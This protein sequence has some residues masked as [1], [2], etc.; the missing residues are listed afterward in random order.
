M[1]QPHPFDHLAAD[2]DR[3][4]SASPIARLLR[5]RVHARLADHFPAGAHL[6]ELGCGTGEDACRLAERGV[7][8]TATDASLLMLA[9]TR[10]KTA[11]LP[12]V[13]V[14]PLD[15]DELPPDGLVGPFDGVFSNFGP[16]NCLDT[17]APLAVWLAARVPPG[18]TAAFG[19]MSRWCVWET[20][21]HGLHGDFQTAARRWGGR[22][23]FTPAPGAAPITIRYPSPGQLAREFAP[24]FQRIGLEPLGLLLPPTAIYPVIE[25]RPRLLRTLAR[26][27][28]LTRRLSGLASL[29]DHYWITLRRTDAPAPIP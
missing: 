19:I 5:D 24:W 29:A 12:L 14:Q 6:L 15:L 7:R 3:D 2:Y 23:Q 22:S 18:G 27:D 21:W 8:V 17:W 11:H 26:I 28:A 1:T 25:R 9:Q 4:F 20:A 16:L 13:D 10:A